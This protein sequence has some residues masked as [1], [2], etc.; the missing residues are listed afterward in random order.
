MNP[1]LSVTTIVAQNT[2]A[3]ENNPPLIIDL[4]ITRC[5][6]ENVYETND[7]ETIEDVKYLSTPKN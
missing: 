2:T 3:I 7:G 4:N 1:P 6:F 5:T